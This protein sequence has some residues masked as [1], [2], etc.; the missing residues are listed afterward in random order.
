MQRNTLSGSNVLHERM[1]VRL[2][3]EIVVPS[4]SKKSATRNSVNVQ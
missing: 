1:G 3:S 2:I 4:N